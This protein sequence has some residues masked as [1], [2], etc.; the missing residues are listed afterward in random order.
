VLALLVL[1]ISV[2]VIM[3]WCKKKTKQ[4]TPDKDIKDRGKYQLVCLMFDGV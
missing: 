2:P 3:Y 4:K 1:V